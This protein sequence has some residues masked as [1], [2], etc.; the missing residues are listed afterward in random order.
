M[1]T[2][3]SQNIHRKSP[4]PPLTERCS[5]LVWSATSVEGISLLLFVVSP[6]S[7]GVV[8]SWIGDERKRKNRKSPLGCRCTQGYSEAKNNAK[9]AQR[10]LFMCTALRCQGS[11]AV[12]GMCLVAQSMPGKSAPYE[13]SM[14]F[15]LLV[16]STVLLVTV[17]WIKVSLCSQ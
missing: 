17:N 3:N 2:Q 15:R 8:Q 6:M 4:F 12:R 5:R 7:V 10:V 16:S 1:G 14:A 13:L 11:L 9:Q